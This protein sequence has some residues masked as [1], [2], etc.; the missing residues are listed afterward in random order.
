MKVVL[1]R[2]TELAK[3]LRNQIELL[4]LEAAGV[5]NWSFY[6]EHRSRENEELEDLS[7]SEVVE[8]FGY[9]IRNI[10]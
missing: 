4:D 5:D 1:I 7:D 10:L 2:V 8:R 3:L 9:T 6:G